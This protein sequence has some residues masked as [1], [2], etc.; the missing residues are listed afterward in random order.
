MSQ[1]NDRVEKQRLK[2]EAEEWAQGVKSIHAHS[3]NS[4]LY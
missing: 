4:S 1:Y 3:L 2:L